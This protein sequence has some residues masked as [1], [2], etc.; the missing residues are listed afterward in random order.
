MP[1]AKA[2]CV[3]LLRGFGFSE[4]KD[5]KCYSQSIRHTP[6]SPP[7]KSPLSRGVSKLL[8]LVNTGKSAGFRVERIK[9]QGKNPAYG[10]IG[11]LLLCFLIM[12]YPLSSSYAEVSQSTLDSL[13]IRASSGMIRYQDEVKPSREALVEYGEEAVDYLAGKMDT[14]SARE[15]HTL[16]DIL[17]EIG[18][19]VTDEVCEQLDRDDPYIVRLACR[20][21]GRIGDSSAVECLLPH[22]NDSLYTIRSGAASALGKIGHRSATDILLRLAHD[23]DYIVRKSATVSL[24]KMP[25]ELV[26]ESLL[27]NLSDEYYGVR[28]TAAA[29]LAGYEKKAAPALKGYITENLNIN[30]SDLP[31]NRVFAVALAIDCLGKI[32]QK[33]SS[34]LLK[35]IVDSENDRIIKAYA[36]RSLGK[37]GGKSNRKF[38]VKMKKSETDPFVSQLLADAIILASKNE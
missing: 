28:Y 10:I 13:W 6:I 1:K 4:V 35:K 3:T 37:I 38:L 32:G 29:S 20:A 34:R 8:A 27:E 30:S 16:V 26:Y 36:A 5:R 15:M 24:G 7:V 31:R 12:V 18:S 23:E 2:G 14:R 21:L 33:K 17:G 11:T 25:F 19:V 22:A 9:L